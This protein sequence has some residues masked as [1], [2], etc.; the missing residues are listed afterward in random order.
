MLLSASHGSHQSWKK[1]SEDLKA[2]FRTVPI[3][4][5]MAKR[6]GDPYKEILTAILKVK[7]EVTT[8]RQAYGSVSLWPA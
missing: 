8:N 3:S 2:S 5:F 7:V 6:D 1:L 4:I